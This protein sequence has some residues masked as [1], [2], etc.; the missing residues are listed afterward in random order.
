MNEVSSYRNVIFVPSNMISWA[1]ILVL[2]TLLVLLTNPV[3]ATYVINFIV[4]IADVL[5]RM[6]MQMLLSVR[7]I[8]FT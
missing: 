1:T 6:A 4:P 7:Y 2:V 3:L 8:I 5:C